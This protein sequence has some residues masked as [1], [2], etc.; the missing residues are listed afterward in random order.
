MQFS[1]VVHFLFPPSPILLALYKCGIRLTSYEGILLVPKQSSVC[2]LKSGLLPKQPCIYQ[3]L[4]P[5]I[6]EI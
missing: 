4:N 6:A 2:G 1:I 3:P 5:L